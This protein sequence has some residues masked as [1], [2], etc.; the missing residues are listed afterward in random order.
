MQLGQARLH[1]YCNICTVQKR[2]A[3]RSIRLDPVDAPSEERAVITLPM[4]P[5][6][7]WKAALSRFR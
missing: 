5:D 6:R 4:P 2:F 3:V 7:E 1:F